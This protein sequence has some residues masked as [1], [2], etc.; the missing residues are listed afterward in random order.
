MFSTFT[1]RAQLEA[2]A[3]IVTKI[4]NILSETIFVMEKGFAQKRESAQELQGLPKI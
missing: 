3:L 1:I 2:N 4:R